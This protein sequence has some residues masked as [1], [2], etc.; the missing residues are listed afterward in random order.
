MCIRDS[1]SIAYVPQTNGRSESQMKLISTAIKALIA[2]GHKPSEIPQLQMAYN[3]A[4]HRNIPDKKSLEY[5][6]FGTTDPYIEHQLDITLSTTSTRA[7]QLDH[8]HTLWQ[9]IPDIL[10][11]AFVKQA[12]NYNRMRTRPNLKV[13]DMVLLQQIK[14]KKT[15]DTFTGP[16]TI[17]EKI[18]DSV[19]IIPHNNKKLTTH[20]NMLKKYVQR[21]STPMIVTGTALIG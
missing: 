20:I 6:L 13:G 10:H 11:E 21:L 12:K 18:S 5:Y 3:L 2:Q 8:L 9:A 17:V 1:T 15:E 7:E 19:Y 4:P 14:P 16:Y